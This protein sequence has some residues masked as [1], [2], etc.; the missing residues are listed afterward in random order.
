MQSRYY[1]PTI[2]RFLN[3]DVYCDTSDSV[4]GTNMFVYCLNNPVACFDSDGKQTATETIGA[5]I[6]EIF[7][8]L[9][10]QEI[11]KKMHGKKAKLTFGNLEEYKKEKTKLYKE[12]FNGFN[13]WTAA[14][15]IANTI[16]GVLSGFSDFIP[17]AE[18]KAAFEVLP[19][20]TVLLK[21][22]SG[23]YLSIQG[24]LIMTISDLSL[25]GVASIA[26]LSLS[27]VLGKFE[28]LITSIFGV[29]L[30]KWTE[31]RTENAAY[32]W[33]LFVKYTLS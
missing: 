16:A 11:N 29:A 17:K 25:D 1:N 23:R 22:F 7:V 19:V 33:Y 4:I 15:D 30:S 14:T 26:G 31:E 32:N 12:W 5:V 8:C 20:I 27:S 21:N 2:G 9:D 18:I 13:Y 6:T 28:S 3:A 10:L 24:A